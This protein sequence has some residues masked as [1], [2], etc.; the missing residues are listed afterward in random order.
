MS[1]CLFTAGVAS[2]GRLRP[3]R[4]PESG[5]DKR[6]A[7]GAAPEVHG[8]QTDTNGEY[9]HCKRLSQF[10]LITLFDSM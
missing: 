9:L 7:S 10:T 8:P 4:R 6:G 3:V 2:Q 5:R 1:L